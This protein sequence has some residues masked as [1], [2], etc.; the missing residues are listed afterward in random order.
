M[1][2]T[3]SRAGGIGRPLRDLEQRGLADAGLADDEQGG[4]ALGADRED[5]TDQLDIRVAADEIVG[6]VPG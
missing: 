6:Q 1:P 3:T 2:R 5:G 4:T